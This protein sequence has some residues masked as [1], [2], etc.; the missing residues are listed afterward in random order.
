MDVNKLISL[1][2][3]ALAETDNVVA[4]S[5]YYSKDAEPIT[6][7][8]KVLHLLKEG[9]QNNSKEINERVLRAMHDL[10]MSAFKEFENTPLEDAINNV[11]EVL[12]YGI[13]YY[14]DL[15]PLRM[16]FGKGDPI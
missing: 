1:I 3:I 11:T 14:S 10:G 2:D 15:E 8:R 6:S 13:P 9:V 16:D 5:K 4:K 7:T 12:Y